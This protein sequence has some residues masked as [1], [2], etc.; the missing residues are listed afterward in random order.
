M[1][2]LKEIKNNHKIW[3]ELDRV[4]PARLAWE[5]IEW[6]IAEVERLQQ[7]GNTNRGKGE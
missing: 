7:A 6:L 4:W 3:T 1:D 2:K 5:A